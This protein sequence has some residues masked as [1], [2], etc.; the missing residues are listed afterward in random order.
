M[1]RDFA[2]NKKQRNSASRFDKKDNEKS[3]PA[4]TWILA[5]LLIGVISTVVVVLSLKESEAQPKIIEQKKAPSAKSRYQAV[6][7]DEASDEDLDFHHLLENKVVEVPKKNQD[8]LTKQSTTKRYIMQCGSFRKIASAESLKA[9]IAMN[10]LTAK[11][12]VTVE[13]SGKKWFRVALGPY[14]SKR[15]A[16]SE[17]HQLERNSINNCR[18]W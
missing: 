10:G 6:P 18:I 15:I 7:A 5:G 13:K 11:I 8:K 16:E 9:T 2:K 3:I 12:S 4:W 1:P 14:E 17:R